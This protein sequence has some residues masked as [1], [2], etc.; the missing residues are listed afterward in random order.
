MGVEFLDAGARFDPTGR[1]IAEQSDS[2]GSSA[3]SG[4]GLMLIRTYAKELA[5]RHDGTYNRVTLK[6]GRRPS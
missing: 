6:I 1:V 2:A 5:Y 4:R 3:I